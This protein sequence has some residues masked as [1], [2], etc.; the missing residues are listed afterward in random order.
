MVARVAPT[1]DPVTVIEA[2]QMWVWYRLDQISEW[3]GRHKQRRRKTF[4]KPRYF[5]AVNV[6][7]RGDS[8]EMLYLPQ[9]HKLSLA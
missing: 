5:V 8:K 6:A 9:T 4:D 1:F 7:V 3:R 2:N